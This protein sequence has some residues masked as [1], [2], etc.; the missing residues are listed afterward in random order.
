M[1]LFRYDG[2]VL[3]NA[4]TYQAMGD[5]DVYIC[6]Q[7]SNANQANPNTT[8]VPPAPLATIYADASGTP[9][10]NPVETDLNGHYFFYALPGI[11]DI[12]VQDPNG[13]LTS[14]QI[15]LDQTIGIAAG[16]GALAFQTNGTPNA[17]QS[18]LNIAAGSGISAVNTGNTV[19]L[20]NTGFSP[21]AVNANLVYA[22][23]ASGAAALPTF[24]AE[25]AADLPAATG[26]TQGAIVLAGDL[27][28]TAALPHVASTHLTAPLPVNQGGSAS[29][30][31]ATGGTSQ[32]LKQ[33]TVGGAVTVG[34]LAFTDI[35]GVAANAQI[36]APTVSSL[37]GIEALAGSTAHQWVTYVDTTG[38]QHQSQPAFS[39]ISGV[40]GSGQITATAGVS[41]QFVT[42]ISSSGVGT[43]A[44]PAFT[45]ISGTIGSGQITATGAV[46][47]N[48]V[49]ALSSSGVGTLAQPAFADISGAASATQKNELQ[50]TIAFSATPV[51]DA[52]VN[53]SNI[54]VL[55]GNVSS[56]TLTG[57]VAGQ[58]FTFIIM[59]DG[60][61]SH[62]FVFPTNVKG[63][64]TIAATISGFNVQDFLYNGTNWLASSSMQSF[65]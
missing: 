31:S 47:H 53:G 51:F 13:R 44:Q 40:V 5:V 54:I 37:G 8:P 12:V 42:A 43:L 55:T 7:P 56:S 20:T 62:T 27:A 18:L 24:R 58:R 9:L 26:S 16:G 4:P 14:T 25:V 10:A 19:T 21:V 52:S 17:D 39:D 32:V 59:Q 48:F 63:A 6:S 60:V 15:Y 35:S 38:I 36:P 64:G 50:A 57:G 30:L 28:N 11:Y 1:P 45:D 22:G 46:A 2:V 34:Q 49:T 3:L 33:V 65:V 29:D 41:H 23:P 61:G